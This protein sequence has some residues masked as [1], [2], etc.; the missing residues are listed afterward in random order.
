MNASAFSWPRRGCCHRSLVFCL[1]CDFRGD[2]LEN[3]RCP[4]SF[5]RFPRRWVGECA[6]PWVFSVI[7]TAMSWRL[8]VALD[9]F[10][11]CYDI[12]FNFNPPQRFEFHICIIPACGLGGGLSQ[13]KAPGRAHRLHKLA[14]NW[15]NWFDLRFCY[16]FIGFNL[17]FNLFLIYF[18]FAFNFVLIF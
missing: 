8:R 4:G 13:A 6:L 2:E 16:C 10:C 15:K 14:P 18:Y 9:L 5:L 12:S 3:A 1:F 17:V 11:E 7:S